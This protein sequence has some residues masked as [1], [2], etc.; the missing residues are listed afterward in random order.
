MLCA[1]TTGARPVAVS[2]RLTA[3]SIRGTYSSIEPNTGS[4]F[5]ATKG[6]CT[7]RK[8]SIHGFHIPRLQ[9]KPCTRTTPRRR[10]TV[11]EGESQFA[12][13]RKG[14]RQRN[15]GGAAKTSLHHA[16]SSCLRVG[17]SRSSGE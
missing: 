3:A 10:G 9:K 5:T 12:R 2:R 11:G 16:E 4:R 15:T 8:R 13:D 1:T 17:R 7:S 6:T 14:C